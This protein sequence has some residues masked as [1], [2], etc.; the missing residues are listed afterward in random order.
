MS[1]VPQADRADTQ[2]EPVPSDL[3]ERY[4]AF[5]E[6]VSAI[7]NSAVGAIGREGIIDAAKRLYVW[8]QRRLNLSSESGMSMLFDF[9]LYECE[10]PRSLI[11]SYI[12]L[13]PGPPDDAVASQARESISRAT[14]RIAQFREQDNDGV[15]IVRDLVRGDTI[16]FF[17]NNLSGLNVAGLCLA[18]RT[19]PFEEVF[20]STGAFL[21]MEQEHVVDVL[22]KLADVGVIMQ[23][24]SGGL[25]LASGRRNA[26][27]F[28][29][30]T[31]RTLLAIGLDE[32]VEY[33]NG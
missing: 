29:A 27:E 12:A 15:V 14:F 33:R 17:D 8:R 3:L 10:G 26:M 4:R 11:Q 13:N 7:Q 16:R 30:V 21:P 28:A 20:V 23:S 32:S 9:A 18:M 1:E 2:A 25:A 19:I 31:I 6:A 5:R 24:K 22:E